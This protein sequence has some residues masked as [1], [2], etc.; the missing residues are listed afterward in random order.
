MEWGL[1]WQKEKAGF[2][3]SLGRRLVVIELL[4]PLASLA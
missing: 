4:T 2:S 3:S 1:S